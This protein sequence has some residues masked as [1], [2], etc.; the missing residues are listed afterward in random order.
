LVRSWVGHRTSWVVGPAGVFFVSLGLLAVY[1][2]CFVLGTLPC[3]DIEGRVNGLWGGLVLGGDSASI[4]IP[5][6]DQAFD[7]DD[8][9]E[10][11]DLGGH[12]VASPFW[13]QVGDI[14]ETGQDSVAGHVD[15]EGFLG[16]LLGEL[17]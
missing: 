17:L 5:I 2:F 12:A 15:P 14:P 10:S 3:G 11:L 16:I 8:H 4:R 9:G 1:G 6:W 13:V 7:G